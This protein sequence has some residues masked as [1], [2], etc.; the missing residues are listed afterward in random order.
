MQFKIQTDYYDYLV[1]CIWLRG[2]GDNRGN[3]IKS[4][5]R[6]NNN[7]LTNSNLKFPF[8]SFKWNWM[9]EKKF[10]VFTESKEN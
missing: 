7:N 3:N 10:Q 1:M 9:S 4:T 6:P 8:L 2:K 5:I